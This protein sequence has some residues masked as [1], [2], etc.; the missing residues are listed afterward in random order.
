MKMDLERLCSWLNDRLWFRFLF[1][2]LDATLPVQDRHRAIRVT[3]PC[4]WARNLP[5]KG[6]AIVSE[7]AEEV[8]QPGSWAP[9]LKGTVGETAILALPLEDLCEEANIGWGWQWDFLASSLWDGK[10]LKMSHEHSLASGW[11]DARVQ[12]FKPLRLTKQ[13]AV[14]AAFPRRWYGCYLVRSPN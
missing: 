4:F 14:G 10:Y 13:W 1:P 8:A 5:G 6:S 7:T 12:G 11:V 3:F 9:L 2:V